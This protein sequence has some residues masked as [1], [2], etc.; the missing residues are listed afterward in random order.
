ME[1]KDNIREGTISGAGVFGARR[2][3]GG[4]SEI[5]PPVLLRNLDRGIVY[6]VTITPTLAARLNRKYK[7]RIN[8]DKT[9]IK[10]GKRISR[11]R[12][13]KTQIKNDQ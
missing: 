13:Q 3:V 10:N 11:R 9:R 5:V 2:E 7:P 8:A 6:E 4:R 1:N 12:P